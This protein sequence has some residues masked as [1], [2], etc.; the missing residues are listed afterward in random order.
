MKKIILFSVLISSWITFAQ[1]ADGLY[2]QINTS[3]GAI[4]VKLEFEKTPITV[5]NFVSLIEGKNSQVDKK[6]E[7][8]PYYDGLKFHRV[9]P[10]FM[11]QG[12]DPDGTG[13]GG[14]GYKF[15]DEITDL[16]HDKPGMLSMANAGAATNGSQFFITHKDTEWLNGK[17]TVFGNVIEGM[18]VVN[19]IAQNDL[20]NT[21]IIIRK[22]KAAKKFKAHKVFKAYFEKKEANDKVLDAHNKEARENLGKVVAEK[23]RIKTEQEA[24]NKKELEA[25]TAT[26]KAEKANYLELQKQLGTQ[27]ASGLIYKVIKEGSGKMAQKGSEIKI[28]YALYLA[29]GEL[30]ETTFE[31]IAQQFGKFD[32]VKKEKN[33]YQPFPFEYGK[34][35][36]LIPG[37]IEGLENIKLGDRALLFIPYQLGYGE[38]RSGPIPPKT[39]LIFE[40]EML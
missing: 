31:D 29:T 24:A 6:F 19:T 33:A 22:G 1:T 40:I 15:A 2:A 3:K 35:S 9:I 23:L 37:F 34:K 25:K 7:K 11:I 27:T 13:A 36:G 28:N 38:N 39:D 5:A 18:D 14:P 30:L 8:K 16:T 32:P 10:N 12:G 26:L 21:V 17:H 4:L 20:I